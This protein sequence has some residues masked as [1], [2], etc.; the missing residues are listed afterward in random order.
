[1]DTLSHIDALNRRFGKK[2]LAEIVAGKGALPLL[3]INCQAGSAEIY[4]HGAHITSWR[5]AGAEEVLFLSRLSEWAPGKPIRGGIPICFPWFGEK[6]DDPSAPKHGFARLRQWRLD[7]L[8]PLDDGGVTLVCVLESDDAT[9]ALWPHQFC[10]AYRITL[11]KTLRLELSVINTGTD[12]LRFEEAL[13]TYF[14]VGEVKEISIP[15]LDLV[16]Y[17]DKNDAYRQK[18]QDGDLRFDGPV[19]RVFLNTAGPVEVTDP[20]LHRRLRTEKLHSETTVVWNPWEQGAAGLSD[21]GDEEWHSMVCVEGS[22]V[23]H[24]A[25]VLG[26]GEEHMLRVTLSVEP[27]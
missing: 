14:H 23:M 20:V 2:G 22:N 7:S 8:T 1:M 25:L 27:E 17:L 15:G 10:T 6:A 12:P 18:Q 26:P 3:R 16:R 5:P 24:E 9:R 4:L 21:F 13:H 11:G 19:D